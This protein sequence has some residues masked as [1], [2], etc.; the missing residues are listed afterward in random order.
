MKTDADEHNPGAP[1]DLATV[2]WLFN[3]AFVPVIFKNAQS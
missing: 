1:V 3:G 2:N